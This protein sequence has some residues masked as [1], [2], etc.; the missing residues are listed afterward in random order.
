[1]IPAPFWK[2]FSAVIL[3]LCLILVGVADPVAAEVRFVVFHSSDM[4]GHLSPQPDP[5]V[6]TEPRPL[7]GGFAAYKTCLDQARREIYLSGGMPVVVDSGDFFQGTPVVDDSKGACMIDLMNRIG[8]LG[9]CL[10]NHDFDYGVPR[11]KEVLKSARF[12]I[13][14]CNLFDKNTGKPLPF[15]RPFLTVPFRGKKIAFI[16]ILTP[17]TVAMTFEEHIRGIGFKDPVPLVQKLSHELKTQREVDCVILLSHMGIQED[18]RISA[19]LKD[20]DLILGGHSHTDMN[21]IEF[22]EHGGPGIVHPGYDGR[23]VSRIDIVLE[24]GR[25]PTFTYECVKLA[26]E[27]FPP[28]PVIQDVVDIY[29]APVKE[30]LREVIGVSKVELVRGIIGGD[31]P[32]GTYVGDAMREAVNADF[33]FMNAGGIRYPVSPGP[34]TLEDMFLLQPFDNSLDV[35]TMTGG[36]IV[37]MIEQSLSVPF[38][39][40]NADDLD[41]AMKNFRLRAKGLKREFQGKYGY[42]IPSNLL[43][44][45][46]PELPEG[47]RIVKLTDGQGKALDPQKKYRV[48]LNSYLSSGGDGFSYL[49][50]WKERQAFPLLL[51]DVVTAKI[52]KDKG[53]HALPPQSMFNLR[54]ETSP[55]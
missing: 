3:A 4:H 34:L 47:R 50:T 29:E 38:T 27:R 28:C 20:V 8:M 33:A 43:I 13:L 14:V 30:K 25:N 41:Y 6:A 52:R 26:V 23:T 42:L 24:E 49:K 40:V 55:L 19:L 32:E 21:A 35:L 54:L 11:L 39:P 12:P 45:F 22:P 18:R 1:M 53:I 17:E 46:D 7:V 5:T 2:R 44:T 37:E 9:A 51:R 10:G 48:A 16:G 31:S 36:Q 15:T